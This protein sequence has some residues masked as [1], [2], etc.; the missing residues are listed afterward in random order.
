[1]TSKRISV[2]LICTVQISVFIALA[3]G[4]KND[5][6]HEL[7]SEGDETGSIETPAVGVVRSIGVE[8][9]A[10]TLE[11]NPGKI[12]DVRTP[13]EFS[14]GHL[15]GAMNFNVNADDFMALC[16]AGLDKS[17]PVYVYCKSGGRSATAA[18]MLKEAGFSN[19]IN[20]EG[21][22][23]AWKDAGRPVNQ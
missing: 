20:M 6:G 14:G 3:A 16:E 12:V 1:M 8:E 13:E 7:A 4:C 9:F 10:Q 23:T 11:Q 15:Q 17:Q 22:I 2:V 5:G 19:I 21:G 18:N